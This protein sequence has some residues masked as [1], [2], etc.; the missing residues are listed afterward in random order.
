MFV[1]QGLTAGPCLCVIVGEE[2]MRLAGSG[3]LNSLSLIQ[4]SSKGALLG[5]LIQALN[6]RCQGLSHSM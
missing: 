5:A 1:K 2:S 6:D 4:C 3:N